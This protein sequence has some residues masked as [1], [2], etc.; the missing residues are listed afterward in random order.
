MNVLL[1][2]GGGREHALAW[3]LAQSP[4]LGT[5]Y[6]APGNPG[7]AAHGQIVP[8]DTG[9]HPAVARFCKERDIGLVVIGPEAPLVAGLAD[10]LRAAGLAVFGPGAAAA[11]LEGSKG[12]T[13]ALC[14]AH[15][16][17]TAAFV[18]VADRARGQAALDR[19]EVPM[20]VKAD[21]LAAGKGVT[22]A[23]TR[24]EA[25][26]ALDAIFAAPGGRA[27]I[28]EFLAGEEAS[29]FVLANGTDYVAFGSAQDHKR[30]GEG[31]T[32]PNTG[33]MGAYSPAPVLTPALEARALAEIV[34]PTLAAMAAAGTPFSGVLYAGLMLTAEGPKLIEYN[35]RFGDPECQVLMARLDSDL[36]PL[37]LAVA[38]GGPI[39]APRFAND[40]A[41]TVVYAARGYP[42]LPET[43]GRLAGLDAAAASGCAVLHAGT[44]WCDGA[45]VA[46]GGRVLAVT[47]R[48]ASLGEARAR[49]Y[50]GVELIDFPSGFYRQDIGWREL[51]RQPGEA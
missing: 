33:G 23:A 3:K 2:G 27:V 10:D 35:V 9:D 42:V 45:L 20:V 49:A 5:L 46:S 14:A 50:Q 22:V 34:A 19:F 12:F 38:R 25:E 13:K 30:V 36:L 39:P 28:E 26:A 29:L 44:A 15:G 40:S 18:E 4:M 1:L 47:A 43:G 21:G 16:I 11:R 37:L 31:D 32:G 7:I 51:A 6:A 48:A 8:L 24:A 17:P 41:L